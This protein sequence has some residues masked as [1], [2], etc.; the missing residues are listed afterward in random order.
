[1]IWCAAIEH[2]CSASVIR[3]QITGP[4]A[5]ERRYCSSSH[6]PV[7]LSLAA[8]AVEVSVVSDES[9]DRN[10]FPQVIQTGL[11]AQ[12]LTNPSASM[13]LLE[14]LW[15]NIPLA[16]AIISPCTQGFYSVSWGIEQNLWA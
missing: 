15:L 3:Q 1:M 6:A 14:F 4:E 11:C 7:K 10:T 9:K 8:G 12:A 16:F 13:L 5:E 2:A